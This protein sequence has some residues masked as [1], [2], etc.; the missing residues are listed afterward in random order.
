MDKKLLEL[1]A[2]SAEKNQAKHNRAE[3]TLS[4]PPTL[5]VIEGGKDEFE[6]LFYKLISQPYTFEQNEFEHLVEVTLKDRLSRAEIFDLATERLRSGTD[7]LERHCI[8]AII[9]G[10]NAEFERLLKILDQRNKLGLSVID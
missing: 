3:R 9:E 10:N 5:S 1:I 6:K 4:S 7:S 8:L 2:G